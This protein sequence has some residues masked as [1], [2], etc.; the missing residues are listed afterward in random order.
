MMTNMKHKYLGTWQI[1]NFQK[2]LVVF[3]NDL[4]LIEIDI[5]I[6]ASFLVEIKIYRFQKQLLLSQTL[7]NS[8]N[9]KSY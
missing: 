8:K 4:D 6:D 7:S 9:S 1:Y 2:L 3:I 5:N